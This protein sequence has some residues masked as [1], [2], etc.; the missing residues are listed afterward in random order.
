M[1]DSGVVQKTNYPTRS[2]STILTPYHDNDNHCGRNEYEVATLPKHGRRQKNWNTDRHIDRQADTGGNEG[3]ARRRRLGSCIQFTPTNTKGKAA[4]TIF[5][6][7][8]K[9]FCSTWVGD[10]TN[11]T[12]YVYSNTKQINLNPHLQLVLVIDSRI[13]WKYSNL[14]TIATT[15]KMH[16][17]FGDDADNLDRMERHDKWGKD[18]L[19]VLSL[20]QTTKGRVTPYQ[21]WYRWCN[22]HHPPAAAKTNEIQA[23][24]IP[25]R[26]IVPLKKTRTRMLTSINQRGLSEL[27]C[28]RWWRHW[29][30]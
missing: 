28:R 7:Q 6:Q 30:F 11:A 10:N 15:R 24:Q 16:E 8:Q 21:S 12:V 18:G 17:S 27:F 20:R 1:D 13:A 22:L 2:P 3:T 14:V 5:G 26:S 4:K 9:L 25:A 19:T 23:M 29:L